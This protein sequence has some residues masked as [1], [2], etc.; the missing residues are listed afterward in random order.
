MIIR[1]MVNKYG[2]TIVKTPRSK[3]F[4]ILTVKLSLGLYVGT[5]RLVATVHEA[6]PIAGNVC[7]H[8]LVR[9][10]ISY[11]GRT[12]NKEKNRLRAIKKCIYF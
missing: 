6:D 3:Y 8:A 5:F 9:V 11:G 2:V 1:I 4:K 12:K 10:Y 7:V